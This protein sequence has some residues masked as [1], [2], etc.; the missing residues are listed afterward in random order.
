VRKRLARRRAGYLFAAMSNAGVAI[1]AYHTLEL[2]ET[3]GVAPFRAYLEKLRGKDKP[4][5]SDR[6]FLADARLQEAAEVLESVKVS[7]PKLAKLVTALAGQFEEHPESLAIVFAQYRDTIDSILKALEAEGITAHRFVG[8]ATR[9]EDKGMSQGEQREVLERFRRGEFKVLV[10][11]SV[12]EEGLDI[13]QVDLVVFYEPVVSE[14]RS[15]QRRGRT[16]RNRP[17]R[18]VVLLTKGTRDVASYWTAK[19]KERAMRDEVQELRQRFAR[20]NA[21]WERP[22]GQ[23]TLVRFGGEVEVDH[24]LA[25]S[26][27]AAALR[28]RGV[29]LKPETLPGAT[30]RAGQTGVRVVEAGDL[31]PSMR[32][33]LEAEL[34]A[35]HR[36]EQPVVLL[37]GEADETSVA[38]RAWQQQGFVV[39]RAR[40]AEQG[41][42]LVAG[43]LGAA[44]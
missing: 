22:Q 31:L 17:G 7:H 41:A 32:G 40:D 44:T 30:F 1:Q 37:L 27:M 18:V 36:F 9:G 15:I 39:R 24:R 3:Q 13:P 29:Q 10:A 8:Q 16:G 4:G 42:E 12:A 6:V 25:N 33:R 2:L 14:I 35:L 20:V 21:S 34:R 5:K 23:M 11:S 43:L 26:P 38:A 28:A 19:R